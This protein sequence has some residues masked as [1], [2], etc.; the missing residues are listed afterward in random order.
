M[1][2]LSRGPLYYFLFFKLAKRGGCGYPQALPEVLVAIA[3]VGLPRTP[4]LFTNVIQ[5]GR[6]Q[7]GNDVSDTDSARKPITL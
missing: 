1:N 6:I 5:N 2:F 3:F 4:K 7:K